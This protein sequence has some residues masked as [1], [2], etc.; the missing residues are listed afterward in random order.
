MSVLSANRTCICVVNQDGSSPR[1]VVESTALA[2]NWFSWVRPG[3]PRPGSITDPKPQSDLTSERMII[4]GTTR[5]GK[6]VV[7]ETTPDR[8]GDQ[9]IPVPNE[10]GA[11]SATLS[12]DRREIL[13]DGN[14]LF[15]PKAT[16]QYGPAPPP[17]VGRTRHYTIGS[18]RQYYTDPSI[19]RQATAGRQVWSLDLSRPG[20]PTQLTTIGT[21]DYRDAIPDGEA[22][23]NI[24]PSVSP[25]GRYVIFTNVSTVD[26]E[27]FVLRLDTKT[28]EVLNLTNATA[29]AVGVADAQATW[30]PDSKH[31]LFSSNGLDGMQIWEMDADGYHAHKLTDDNYI[32]MMP[33][34]SPDGRYVV[35]A[36]YRGADVGAT[37]GQDLPVAA[38]NG[39][40]DLKH[41]VLVRLDLAT[42]ERRILVQSSQSPMFRPVYDPDG[43]KIYYIGIS[44]PPL[45]SDVYVVDAN[46][47]IGRPLQVTTETFETAVSIR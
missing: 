21:E 26:T 1:V 34:W 12:P 30:S 39:K 9:V 44:G 7:I 13:F 41:W 45:Q 14:A 33:T 2:I 11:Q 18:L 8:F 15:D 36:S 3:P 24:T 22:R 28:G 19:L 31:V 42:G 4:T 32:N 5:A 27:S 47:G 20:P 38:A 37:G 25:D 46:G 29:G 17:G 43:S 40:V 10:L 16:I 6:H 35:Y 23:G